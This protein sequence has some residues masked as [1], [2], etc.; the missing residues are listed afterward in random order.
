MTYSA[1]FQCFKGCPDRFPLTEVIYR[2]PSCGDLLEVAH[3]VEALATREPAEWMKLFDD[4]YMT[5][6][7]PYG[8]RRLGQEGVR[9]SRI[10]R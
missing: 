2:C 7:W 8:R 5:T 3:D 10:E 1:W 6:Q 4:R 9:S